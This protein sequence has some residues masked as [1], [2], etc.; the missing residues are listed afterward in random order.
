[1]SEPIKPKLLILDDEIDMLRLLKRS[2][3]SDLHCDV[4]TATDA[5]QALARLEAG[6]FDVVLADVR[7]PGMDGMEF[8]SNV[9]RDHPSLTVVMMT[10]Y[11]SIDLAVQ[12]IKSGAYDFITKPFEHDK[13]VHLLYKALER[14]RLVRENLLLQQRI[15]QQEGFYE[16]VGASPKIRKI[17]D[18]IRLIS[19]TDVTVLITGE[20]GTGKDMAAHAI[21]G[22]SDRNERSFVAVNCPNLPETILESELFGHKKGAFTD[23]TKDKVGLFREAEGGTIY[24]DEI[25]DISPT[26][27]TKLLR[28][29]QEKEIRPVGDTKTL[30]VDVRILA[31][32]NQDLAAKIESNL[33][34]EDLFYRLNVLSLHLP[35]LRDRPEDIPLLTSHF[36]KKF[37]LEFSTGPKTISPELLHR[38]MAHPWR[39]NV[40]ELENI[41]SRAVLLSSGSVI[42][43][44][45][46]DWDDRPTE[47][48]LVDEATGRLPY[49]EAKGRVLHRFHREYLADILVRNN[50]NVTRAARE[51][52][53]ERQ[54]LQQVM[55]RYGINPRDFHASDEPA[56]HQEPSE[57]DEAAT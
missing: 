28:V 46:L 5:Y 7:M 52:G 20:S 24:L 32:T 16:M 39:G 10:A 34:R 12:A 37:R 45:D 1:M 35:P 29:L 8:L 54:A 27:Q 43:P 9:K 56:R 53:L 6:L 36:L 47:C 41:I 19:K 33:F 3:T 38:L 49:K 42:H 50:G 17:F 11:G 57:R 21:H 23:A 55:K 51:C 22:L 31:S 2:L 13:L 30:K 26:L 48:V 40:R 4:E 14:S 44:A 25:G 18:T 15:R